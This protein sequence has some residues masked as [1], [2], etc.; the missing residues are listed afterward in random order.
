MVQLGFYFHMKQALGV[1]QYTLTR[2]LAFAVG[3]MLFV[4]IVIALFKDIP[5]IQG[6][7][8]VHLMVKRHQTLHY[9]T[10]LKIAYSS[11][12][13]HFGPSE[14]ATVP[15]QAG[16]F[17]LSVRVGAQQVFWACISLLELAYAGAVAFGL[18]SPV[19]IP[20]CA[21]LHMQLHP[22]IVPCRTRMPCTYKQLP[23]NLS[24][25]CS[26]VRWQRSWHICPWEHC[27]SSERGQQT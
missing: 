26:G 19:R 25:R 2:P 20:P 14:S 24:R 13:R 8:Q 15:M 10:T 12:D 18:T 16:I 4:S 5:D 7:R 17:T 27:C 3:F 22:D 21:S 23:C 9:T 1:A 6:D 11:M